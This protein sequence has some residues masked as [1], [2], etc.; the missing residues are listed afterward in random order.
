MMITATKIWNIR[1]SIVRMDILVAGVNKIRNNPGS[2]DND[3]SNSTETINNQQI[4]PHSCSKALGILREAAHLLG[5]L[6]H[7]VAFQRQGVK[8]QI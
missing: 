4:L 1:I 8:R 5:R 6:Q 2:N 7:E 3:N